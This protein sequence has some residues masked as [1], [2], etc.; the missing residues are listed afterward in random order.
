MTFSEIYGKPTS[1]DSEDLLTSDIFGCCS[2][3]VYHDFLEHILNEALHFN[4]KDKLCI[5][6]PVLSD[7]YLFW[8]RF[9]IRRSQTEPDVLILLRHPGNK[10][11]LVLIEAKFNSGKSSEA[12]YSTEDV[13][14]Q[15]ARELTII[16]NK[17]IYSQNFSLEGHEIKAKALI[18]VTADDVIPEKTLE[19]SSQEFFEKVKTSGMTSYTTASELPFYWLPWWKIEQLT[20]SNSLLDPEEAAK[21]RVIKHIR[22][23]L[24]IKRLCRFYGLN[25]LYFDPI[26]YS[27]SPTTEAKFK[28]DSCSKDY[29]FEITFP[30]IPYRYLTFETENKYSFRLEIPDININITRSIQ[31][32]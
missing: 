26:P 1:I 21:N 5:N 23:V 3:L 12:D 10:F 27:Y 28:S 6:E 19:D 24:R 11:T 22:D 18:Y 30:K 32:E 29:V 13:T 17:D 8:P 4:S 2:F 7:E 14:D 20:S 9:R 31:Y 25:P 15:L 16:E